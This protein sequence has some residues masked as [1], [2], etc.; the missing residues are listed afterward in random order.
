M[1]NTL[2]PT[3]KRLPV[4]FTH[5]EGAYLFDADNRRY[6]DAVCGIAVTNLGHAHPD[7]TQ[8]IVEQAGTLLHTSNL[9]QI[10]WQQELGSALTAAAGMD[11]VFFANSGAEANE[12]AIKLA[13]L[14]ARNLQIEQPKI[15]VMEHSFHGRTNATLAATGNVNA[16]QGFEPLFPGFVRVPFNDIEAIEALAEQR[17]DIAAVLVEP[18]Q[19]EGGVRPAD[20]GYLAA[21]RKLCDQQQWLMMLDEIQ[22]GMGRTGKLFAFQHEPD[23]RPDVLTLAKGLGNGV[24][25]GACLTA[26][27]ATPLFGPGSHGSTFG[28][29]PLACRVGLAVLQCLQQPG[30]LEQVQQ[31]ADWIVQQLTAKL[32]DHPGVREIRGRGYLIG[33]ELDVDATGLVGKALAEGLLINVT[34]QHVVRLLPPLILSQD[35]AE[36]LCTQVV[37]HIEEH[38]REQTAN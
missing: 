29:N 31:R 30:F 18:V 11:K 24:P 14:H 34:Q 7:I 8:A 37:Q 36:T 3:Y 21:L 9:Y 38:L 1:D 26:G 33:I 17:N 4:A 22:T 2:L 32:K 28:G 16:Q 19:G 6:L 25:I 12:A 10:P 35:Q 23:V 20:I 5:G 13:R 15:I 27:P